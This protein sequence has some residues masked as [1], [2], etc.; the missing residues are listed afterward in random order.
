MG[1]G[2]VGLEMAVAVVELADTAMMVLERRQ[3]HS[4]VV[5]A[6]EQEIVATEEALQQ[7]RLENHRLRSALALSHKVLGEFQRCGFLELMQQLDG[8]DAT[9][10]Q[11]RLKKKVESRE[12]LEKMCSLHI[13]KDGDAF[14]ATSLS[15][16]DCSLVRSLA[17]ENDM[18]GQDFDAGDAEGYIVVTQEDIYDGIACFL[19]RFVSTMPKAKVLETCP[20]QCLGTL[21]SSICMILC[22]CHQN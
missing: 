10:F 2:V 11:E 13:V 6:R 21:C 8:L 7:E 12:F 19:A 15:E 9:E 18:C 4:A 1:D 5:L 20:D 22:S 3:E 17:N 16:Q 14:P